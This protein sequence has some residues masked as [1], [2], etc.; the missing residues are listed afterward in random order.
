[1]RLAGDVGL[2]RDD[3]AA[4]SGALD[5][6][7]TAEAVSVDELE[8]LRAERTVVAD[9]EAQAA[10]VLD[11]ARDDAI[12]T[13]ARLERQLFGTAELDLS[14]IGAAL[15]GE[16]R[17]PYGRWAEL[18]LGMFG[19][20]TCRNNL[21]VVVAWQ[22]AEGTQAAWNPL[23]TTHRMP[24]STSFNSVGV[25][26]FVSLEQGLLGTKETIE[27]GWDV[28]RYGAIVRSLQGCAE[29]IETALAI[30]A[31]SWCPGC[32]DG[33]YVLNVVPRV[34]ADLETYLRL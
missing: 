11:A 26:D 27:N 30:N 23:A 28:Y 32:V 22:A 17:V 10:T 2:L 3:L 14:G 1:V 34:E 9:A 15:H 6:L 12:A 31:S 8:A 33:Q 25:Q 19:A 7:I 29:P 4:R 20:P 5:A 21:V 16:Q 13:V 18:F 24:R